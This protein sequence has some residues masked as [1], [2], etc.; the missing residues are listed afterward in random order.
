MLRWIHS[1][2]L[3]A[4]LLRC[5]ADVVTMWPT[6]PAG[7]EAFHR[8]LCRADSERCEVL[9][10]G[11]LDYRAYWDCRYRG[12]GNSG[13]GS[14]GA[15]AEY[16]SSV[17]QGLIDTHGTESLVDFGCGDGNQISSIRV[18]RYVGLDISKEAV[19]LCRERFTGD[20]SRSFDLYRPGQSVDGA[21]Y[22]MAMSLE[23]LMRVIDE[24]DFVSTLDEMFMS[25]SRLVVI[26]TP[27]FELVP[28][29][30]GS[31][32][33]HRNL[34]PYLEKYDDWCVSETIIHPSVTLEDRKAGRIGEMA[35]GFTVLRRRL[36]AEARH[37]G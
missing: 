28:Y 7:T 22:D 8:R 16:K 9:G 24:S 2:G 35:S 14:Y 32:E 21:P 18:A 1:P 12:G 11:D 4:P 19:K 10:P 3:M 26:L 17:I 31:H 5:G 23:V 13:A 37:E 15:H 20:D 33:R 25:A 27:I 29:T 36:A 34:A 30:P 6:L